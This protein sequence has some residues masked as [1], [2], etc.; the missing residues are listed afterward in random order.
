M[1]RQ[2]FAMTDFVIAI[3][4]W[5]VVARYPDGR[6]EQVPVGAWRP[7]GQDGLAPL[8]RGRGTAGALLLLAEHVFSGASLE[9]RGPGPRGR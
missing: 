1:A 7:Q 6:V 9:L 5:T 3:P 2:G 8:V 4:G